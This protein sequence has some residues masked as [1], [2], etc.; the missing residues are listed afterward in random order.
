MPLF[1]KIR[2]NKT[3]YCKPDFLQHGVSEEGNYYVIVELL[4]FDFMGYKGIPI[5]EH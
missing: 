2:Q 1:L 4:V 5:V 3:L